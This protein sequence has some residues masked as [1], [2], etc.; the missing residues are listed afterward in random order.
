MIIPWNTDAPIYHFPWATLGLITTNIAVL[1]AILAGAFDIETLGNLILVYGDGLHPTQWVTSV[2]LHA[3][4]W[5]L[6]GNMLFL[7]AFGLVVEGKLGWWR[8][9]A[10]YLGLAIVQNAAEQAMTFWFSEGGSLGASGVIFGLMA[11]ALVW[12]P[13]NEMNC[14]GWFFIR[15]F[16]FDIRILWF[17]LLY[18]GEEILWVT[19]GGFAVSSELFHS[20]G[21]LLGFG[22]ALVMLKLD[23]VDCEG[24]DLLSVMAGTNRRSPGERTVRL[25]PSVK[26]AEPESDPGDLSMDTVAQHRVRALEPLRGLLAARKGTAALALYQKT[27]HLCQTW[28]LPEKELLQLAELLLA[29]KSWQAAVSFLEEYLRRF[30]K[31]AIPVRLRLAQVLIEQ[32]QRPSYASRIL[33]DLPR[34]GLGEK[35]EKLR[36]AAR[37]KSQKMIEDGVIELQGQ[38]W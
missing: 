32:Q 37:T 12:A 3:G 28:E 34:T 6:F 19:V 2:F 38:A 25:R 35:E 33:A 11:M 9:L 4:F 22:L 30:Q 26:T 14:L 10:V 1:A 20:F 7:W 23:W 8:F 27:V 15:P 13:E 31:K 24:W 29:E 17:A 18:I 21:A 16:A 5:H 36:Q